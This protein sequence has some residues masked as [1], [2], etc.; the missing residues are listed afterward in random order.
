MK[1]IVSIY[2]KIM[3]SEVFRLDGPAI[4]LPNVLIELGN[5]VHSSESEEIF[6][7]LGEGNESDIGSLIIG[8]YWSLTEWHAG[9]AS[10]SYAA[11]CSL[12]RVFSPGLSDGP[13]NESGEYSA[14]ELCNAWFVKGGDA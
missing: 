14:Y 1:R 2:D 5:A 11:L 13:E 7:G 8:A 4:D 9:Q 6:W 3:S 12:G 10:P